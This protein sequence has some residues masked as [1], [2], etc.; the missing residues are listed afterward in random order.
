MN[1]KAIKQLMKE[2]KITQSE[3]AKRL[4]MSQCVLSQKINNKRPVTVYEAER[5]Q[6]ILEIEDKEFRFYFLSRDVA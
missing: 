3:A 4:G 2:K 5:L 1:T 6:E